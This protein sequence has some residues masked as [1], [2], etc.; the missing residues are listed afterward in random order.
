MV[1]DAPIVVGGGFLFFD[2][3]KGEY[4]GILQLEVAETVA[5]KAVGLLST[6]LPDGSKGFS[7]VII[8]SAEGFA[9]IQLGFGFTLTGIGGLLGINRSVLV[10]ALRA[11]LKTGTL[12]AL[13][14]PAD[15]VRNAPQIVSALRAVFP[16]VKERY[17]FGPMAI[18]AWGTP[19]LLTLQLGLLLEL[20]DP[21]RLLILGRL[22]ALLPDAG[23]ALVQVRLD[24][25]GVIDFNRSE[26]A[27]DATLYDSRILQ[28]A[29][30][31]DMALRANWGSQPN[32]VLA[33]GGFHPRFA[34]PAGFP[35][36]NRLALSL[37]D[38]DDLQLRCQAYLALTSNTV[39]FGARLDLHAAGGGFSFD[40]MLG[41]D[42][43]F[44]LS[45]FAFVVDI[46]AAL[47]LRY[48][49]HLLL[50]IS[51]DGTL[52]GPTPWQV[53]GK[54]TIKILFFKVSV[55]FDHQFGAEQPPP[56]PPAVDVVAQ[57]VAALGDR[58]NW[59]GALARGEPP[60]V[61]IRDTAAT[62]A[63]LLVHPLAQLTVRERVAP[64]N[65]AIS[66]LGNAPLTGG[67]TT[68]TLAAKGIGATPLPITATAVR[69]PFALAQYQEMSDDEKL[70][71]PSFEA[72]DAGLQFGVEALAY[73]YDALL[74]SAI[75]YETL[76][77][78]PTRPPEPAAA[79][80]V[81]PQ[82]VL[83]AVVSLGAAGQA[84]FRRRG[85]NRYRDTALAA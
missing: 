56:L 13:L 36:L 27:L 2:P 53:T 76:L 78:D 81:M 52:A 31:G 35:A 11:G 9:P 29:L 43:L 62:T 40:G 19:T 25:L 85:A 26:L 17:V 12:G 23:H 38:G 6:R 64:L 33:L 51:F 47:A 32:F 84:A 60:V 24:A 57:V 82:S 46:A 83:D 41:F 74:D 45:P 65:R 48:H 44:Q 8:L 28:F 72:L 18:I 50:G 68:V 70:A 73:E 20:P 63:S 79:A 61:T 69:E 1:V 34:A 71:R 16:P 75:A 21:V 7:L 58:R 66:K 3:Q 5:V 4:G 59:S 42:A 10:E 30:T 15:P 54:A 14:F 37:S 22:Q 39:Q 80:Y 77:I 49:G 67:A 55:H